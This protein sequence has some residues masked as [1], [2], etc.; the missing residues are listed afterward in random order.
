MRLRPL[1]TIAALAGLLS[2]DLAFAHGRHRD[3][4][5][6]ERLGYQ[7]DLTEAQKARIREIFAERRSEGTTEAARKARTA[8]QELRVLARDPAADEAS[9]RDAASRLADAER[10]L[11][12]E[13]QRTYAEVYKILTP[14]QQEK[15]KE[16]RSRRRAI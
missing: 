11:A 13:R 16:L 12:M 5:R 4:N 9:I 3:G 1:L 7:L 10:E 6:L 2:T 8:R 14:E 15:M